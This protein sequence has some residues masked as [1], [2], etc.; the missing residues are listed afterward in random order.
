MA[1][2]EVKGYI[3]SIFESKD[4]NDSYLSNHADK[5]IFNYN[6]KLAQGAPS[7]L[8]AR[9]KYKQYIGTFNY[10]NAI[11]LLTDV[12]NAR[13][14]ISPKLKN[15]NKTE[16]IRHLLFSNDTKS[17]ETFVAIVKRLCKE[18]PSAGLE[19]DFR[20][21]LLL[22][23][24]D[25]SR[26]KWLFKSGC[27]QKLLSNEN[28]FESN[29]E[30]NEGLNNHQVRAN[31]NLLKKAV[32]EILVAD[33]GMYVREK[34]SKWD[35]RKI[36][37][38]PDVVKNI[39]A[40]AKD[41]EAII[42]TLHFFA[43]ADDRFDSLIA[44]DV[45]KDAAEGDPKYSLISK[46]LFPPSP[47]VMDKLLKYD[48]WTRFYTQDYSLPTYAKVVGRLGSDIEEG[49]QNAQ[50]P[51][52]LN[53]YNKLSNWFKKFLDRKLVFT[54]SSKKRHP[55]Y[56]HLM[57][58]FTNPE[59][60]PSINPKQR[61]QMLKDIL[62]SNKAAGKVFT[63]TVL[64]KMFNKANYNEEYAEL[65]FANK[66]LR[67]N[68]ELMRF[69]NHKK[70]RL[71]GVA[72]DSAKR[73]EEAKLD[74]QEK[75]EA[76]LESQ[77]TTV[78]TAETP[79]YERLQKFY[80]EDMAQLK[81]V[82]AEGLG[83]GSVLA[84]ESKQEML[85]KQAQEIAEQYARIN[86]LTLQLQQSSQKCDEFKQEL[87]SVSK[88]KDQIANQLQTTKELL[89]QEQATSSAQ[90]TDVNEQNVHLEQELLT[91][92]RD[93]NELQAANETKSTRLE[94]K[95][96]ETQRKLLSAEQIGSKLVEVQEELAAKQTLLQQEQQQLEI[97]RKEIAELRVTFRQ[98]LSSAE[99]KHT[100]AEA[101]LKLAKNQEKKATTELETA[102]ARIKDFESR[103]Y[104]LES[105]VKFYESTSKEQEQ[106]YTKQL[107]AAEAEKLSLREQLANISEQ[108]EQLEQKL[109]A[110]LTTHAQQIQDA[111][112]IKQQLIEA[113][114]SSKENQQKLR[115]TNGKLVALQTKFEMEKRQWQQIA[116]ED[117][118]KQI[119]STLL[120]EQKRNELKAK[121]WSQ[122]IQSIQAQKQDI[123]Q[124]LQTAARETHASKMHQ[125]N[126][127][128][129]NQALK[130]QLKQLQ[131]QLQLVDLGE[132]SGQTG[133]GQLLLGNAASFGEGVPDVLR[134][135]API[136][137][138]RSVRAAACSDPIEGLSSS[139]LNVSHN[140]DSP[141]P[142]QATP[143]IV[144]SPSPLARRPTPAKSKSASP[145]SRAVTITA[146]PQSRAPTLS[147]SPMSRAPTLSPSPTV[148]EATP[149]VDR[150]LS[151]AVTPV[152]KGF[153]LFDVS[154]SL[155]SSQPQPADSVMGSP[156]K[157]LL[158]DFDQA[159]LEQIDKE[160]ASKMYVANGESS[161]VSRATESPLPR[162]PTP[163]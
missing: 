110:T 15:L 134:S 151:R 89:D 59:K 112:S 76:K 143:V 154:P 22:M 64:E 153:G 84:N 77:V 16:E 74:L 79:Y 115:Q 18:P 158:V 13:V 98:E 159:Y 114:K 155:H 10:N 140:S 123:E 67:K 3:D 104:T 137:L 45:L 117:L 150:S 50:S 6:A 12:N 20:N 33:D 28:I 23:I 142:R 83:Q 122:Q 80:Q 163:L 107:E 119:A 21:L 146:S 78:I 2:Q 41:E 75:K 57:S 135:N 108:K 44:A 103:I 100:A 86:E 87:Q 39:L 38:T 19:E 109:Q 91:L 128:A 111:E 116:G 24:R 129:Q 81:S 82:A 118:K 25:R 5:N 17:K 34:L 96:E 69:V 141:M 71:L 156:R 29:E 102:T 30:R 58:V 120:A 9:D 62:S 93:L 106:K 8:L 157:S 121:E 35:R 130:Q 40:E 27:L 73:S 95:C 152:L 70:C 53:W 52:Y 65:V 97:L 88:E 139:N 90:L 92:Q 144:S 85:Q 131:A 11:R 4:I 7:R 127:E 1:N 51:W 47:Q 126:L 63:N 42:N 32:V 113:N 133:E 136:S 138:D 105:D 101:S 37:Y 132:K 60:T 68:A 56:Q 48:C 66:T 55:L 147:P 43:R 145:V 72:L 49:K 14:F 161:P 124:Q 149:P 94:Q 125:Q 46:V 31:L 162:L 99:E 61:L 148:R 26:R 54:Q 36:K 160:A